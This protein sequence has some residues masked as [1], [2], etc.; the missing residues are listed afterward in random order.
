MRKYLEAIKKTKAYNMVKRDKSS[1]RLSHSYLLVSEDKEYLEEFAKELAKIMLDVENNEVAINKVDKDIHPDVLV[2]G[3]EEKLKTQVASEISTDAYVRPYE[4]DSKVYLILNMQDANDAS[5]NKLLKIIEEPPKSVFFILASTQENKL[6]NTILS[7]CKKIDLDLIDR[8]TIMSMLLNDGVEK[9]L[10]E[11]CASCAGGIY[12]R[13]FKMSTDKEFSTLYQNIFNCLFKMNSSRDVLAFSS[14]F[15]QKNISKEEF[16]DLFMLIARDLLMV[17]TG[18]VSLVNNSHKIDEI[19]LISQSFSISAL[20]N[21]IKYCL[22]LKED[23]VYNTNQSAAVD[24]FLL[25]VVEA[26]VKCKE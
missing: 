17:R 14:M 4:G 7:R 19:K 15:S 3:K 13:A 23:L 20:N 12:S 26:K 11:I 18:A 9:K 24:H 1:G 5:Q 25:S 21:I 8:E 10:A 22:Q 6:L 2:Y 16:A